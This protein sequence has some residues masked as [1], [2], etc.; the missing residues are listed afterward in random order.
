MLNDLFLLKD[1]VALVTGGSGDIGKAI[2]HAF[3]EAG[4]HLALNGQTRAKLDK[5]Q[6]ELRAH[7]NRVDTFLA[8]VSAPAHAKAL[9][10]QVNDALGGIDILV[11]CAGINRRKPILDVSED[12]YE[13]IMN[14]HL[15]GTFFLSQAVAPIMAQRGG[16]KII[17]I[18]SA[19]IHTGVA[20]VSVYG[21]A[22]AGMDALTRTMAVEWAEHNIQVNTLAPGFIMTELTKDGLWGNERRSKWLFDRI[23]MK[24]AGLP[25]EM[26][27]VALMF[28]SKASSYL[29]GQTIHID[30]GFAAGSKW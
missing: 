6:H 16:G 1:K 2:A 26:A 13:T 15:R 19:T 11:N 10:A 3:A 30:G 5:A 27:G 22:K 12:D 14:V 29:T 24:R 20:D 18:G 28:A 7:G 23:P 8:D 17:N 21:A 4:A 9:V 25:E